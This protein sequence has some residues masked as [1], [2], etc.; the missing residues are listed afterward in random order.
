MMPLPTQ[1]T[2]RLVIHG[3]RSARTHTQRKIP[4]ICLLAA[5][6]Y[7]CPA[8]LGYRVA[9]SVVSSSLLDSGFEVDG[10]LSSSSSDTMLSLSSIAS[11]SEKLTLSFLGR[12]G[13]AS[14]AYG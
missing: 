9:T 4:T 6:R 11:K 13:L 2:L 10:S 7:P 1:D 14:V 5:S 12:S 3:I 8:D